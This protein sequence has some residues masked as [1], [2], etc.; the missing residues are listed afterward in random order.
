MKTKAARS[1]LIILLTL[2]GLGAIFG[3]GVLIISPSG[4]AFVSIKQLPFQ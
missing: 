3:G 4:A 1:I 2:L